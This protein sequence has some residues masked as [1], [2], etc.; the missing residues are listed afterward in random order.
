[1]N[2]KVLLFKMVTG[3]LLASEGT[4]EQVKYAG[5]QGWMLF[6]AQNPLDQSYYLI[7]LACVEAVQLV[8]R[9]KLMQGPQKVFM[10]GSGK[11]N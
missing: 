11:P 6:W 7:G 9:E 5:E 1:V 2:E 3:V 10:P 8:E 4:L